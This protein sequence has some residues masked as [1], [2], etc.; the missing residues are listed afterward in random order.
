MNPPAGFF[1]RLAQGFQKPL[2]IL[3]IAKDR[4]ALIARAMT[5]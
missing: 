5:W 1:A 2:T 3:V 4:P